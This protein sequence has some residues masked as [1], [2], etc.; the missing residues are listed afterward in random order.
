MNDSQLDHLLKNSASLHA[1]P[2]F[3]ADV[4]NRIAAEPDPT[5]LLKS[6]KNLLSEIFTRLSQPAGALA[7]CAVLVTAGSLIGINSR[8]ESLPAE[9]QYIQSVSPFIHQTHR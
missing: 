2:G 1:P 4:W 6:W 7:T 3:S 5:S 8:P 9:V